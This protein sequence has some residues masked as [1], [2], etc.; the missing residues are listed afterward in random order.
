MHRNAPPTGQDYS[1]FYLRQFLDN[2]PQGRSLFFK[3]ILFNAFICLI[4]LISILKPLKFYKKLLIKFFSF[5]FKINGNEYKIYHI[6][7]LI[8]GF[9]VTLYA[10]LKINSSNL[11]ALKNE[12]YHARMIRLNKKWVVE[13]EIWLVF[14]IILCLVSIYRNA[15]LFNQELTYEKDIE[16]IDKELKNNNVR[17]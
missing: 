13:A 9:Y 17:S 10:I 14:F 5:G 12:N 7:F 3:F 15:N 8:I 2:N 16:D 11:I 1:A 6:L 4:L